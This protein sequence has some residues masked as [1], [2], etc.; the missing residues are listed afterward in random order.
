MTD[1]L[2]ALNAAD[3]GSGGQGIG[4]GLYIGAG[5][6]TLTGRTEVVSNFASTSNDNIYG[7]YTT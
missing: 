6:T 5:M 3:G 4:G 1:T 2:I 7:S